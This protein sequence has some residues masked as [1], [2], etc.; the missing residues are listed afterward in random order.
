MGLLVIVPFLVLDVDSQSS[1]LFTIPPPGFIN[2]YSDI[3]IISNTSNTTG[4]TFDSYGS[5]PN[6][7]IAVGHKNSPSS[8][9]SAVIYFDHPIPILDNP[10]FENFNDEMTSCVARVISLNDIATVYVQGFVPPDNIEPKAKSSLVGLGLDFY[11]SSGFQ[12]PC[13]PNLETPFTN[14]LITSKELLIAIREKSDKS[15]YYFSPRD[16]IL[17]AQPIPSCTTS[18]YN[19][20][21]RTLKGENTTMC[22][23]INGTDMIIIT[24]RLAGFYGAADTVT[25]PDNPL[26]LN[27]GEIMTDPSADISRDNVKGLDGT[28]LGFDITT[29]AA[30]TATID[31]YGK[32]TFALSG[33]AN[34]YIYIP[35]GTT[36]SNDLFVAGD[37]GKACIRGHVIPSHF[38]SS[39]YGIPIDVSNGTA[40]GFAYVD[41]NTGNTKNC[42]LRG[43]NVTAPLDIDNTL[44]VVLY[45]QSDKEGYSYLRAANIT[46]SQDV[47]ACNATNFDNATKT[48]L[49]NT[50]M[51]YTD[52]GTD[53]VIYTKVMQFYGATSIDLPTSAT[54]D[55][56]D[57]LT[58]SGTIPDPV[59]T[60]TTVISDA[61]VKTG[62]ITTSSSNGHTFT[63]TNILADRIGSIFV[64]HEPRIPSND[65]FTTARSEC[66]LFPVDIKTALDN[67]YVTG[68]AIPDNIKPKA[69]TNLVALGFDMRNASGASVS[70]SPDLE[71]NNNPGPLLLDK[72]LYITLSNKSKKAPYYISPRDNIT[73]A[74]QITACSSDNFN[75]NNQTLKGTTEMCYGKNG[76]DMVI[77]T[78]RL[79]GF[80]GAANNVTAVS[81][82]DPSIP[83]PTDPPLPPGTIKIPPPDDF[84]SDVDD[85]GLGL[86]ATTT[87]V[88][89]TYTA[90][91]TPF[92]DNRHV[93]VDGPQ[94]GEILVP[95]TNTIMANPI[96]LLSQDVI[97]FSCNDIL[98]K[99]LNDTLDSISNIQPTS[100]IG[101]GY[102]FDDLRDS[103]CLDLFNATSDYPLIVEKE[104]RFTIYGKYDK[105][106]Y[107]ISLPEKIN[108]AQPIPACSSTN[109][110][111]NN[112]TLK[113][114]T[115]MC[116]GVNGTNMVIITKRISGYYGAADTVTPPTNPADLTATAPDLDVTTSRQDI[117]GIGSVAAFNITSGSLGL[118]M[119][120]IDSSGKYTYSPAASTQKGH[121]YIP[122][123]TYLISN[124]DLFVISDNLKKCISGYM[125][126]TEHTGAG[127][128]LPD[129]VTE[130]VAYGFAYNNGPE[131]CTLAATAMNVP[132]DTSTTFHVVLY[133]QAGKQG[134]SYLRAAGTNSSQDIAACSSTNFDNDTKILIHPT[135][136]CYTDVGDDLVIYSR[137]MQWYG[138]K[139]PST[140]DP[141][142]GTTD[143]TSRDN[144]KG[145]GTNP[146][147]DGLFNITTS[148]AGNGSIDASGK[149][150][151]IAGGAK[152][153][154]HIYIAPDTV[155]SDDLF[156][157][158]DVGK[159]CVQG[160][161]IPSDYSPSFSRPSDVSDGTAYGFA[162]IAGPD[163]DTCTL[164]LSHLVGQLNTS[165]TFQVVL[166]DQA[167]KVGYY[168]L[169]SIGINT[170]Q[171][172]IACSSTNFDDTSKTLKGTTRYCYKDVG[173]DLVIY[174]KVIQMYGAKT[175]GDTGADINTVSRD[176]VYGIGADINFNITTSAA[177]NGSIDTSGKYTWSAVGTQPKGHIYIPPDTIIYD[178]LFAAADVGKTCMQ[179]RVIPSDY[180]SIISRPSDLSDGTAYGFLYLVGADSDTCTLK[181]TAFIGQFNTSNTLQVVL[182]EQAGKEG[183]YYHPGININTSQDMTECS[184]TIF[185]NSTK[186]FKGTTKHCYADVGDDLVIYTKVLLWY[187]A[188]TPST[189]DLLTIPKP[190]N[191]P[192][193]QP[194]STHLVQYVDDPG[195]ETA[196]RHYVVD[197]TK[198]DI[199]NDIGVVIQDKPNGAVGNVHV[200]GYTSIDNYTLTSSMA[201][202]ECSIDLWSLS[203]LI[204]KDLVPSFNIPDNISP[205]DQITGLG[206][207]FNATHISDPCKTDIESST[208]HI[209]TRKDLRFTIYNSTGKQPYYFSPRENI[210]QAQPIPACTTDTIYTSNYTLKNTTEMCYGKDG[211]DLVILTKRLAFYGVNDTGSPSGTTPTPGAKTPLPLLTIPKPDD[212]PEPEKRGLTAAYNASKRDYWYV[213]TNITYFIETPS[214]SIGDVRVPSPDRLVLEQNTLLDNYKKPSICPGSFQSVGNILKG[215]FTQRAGGINTVV[216]LKIPSN[217]EEQ[218]SDTIIAGGI[219]WSPS[220]ESDKIKCPLDLEEQSNYPIF[221][222]KELRYTLYNQSDK[223]A[224]HFSPRENILA[225][226]PIPACSNDNFDITDQTLKGDT[227]M[228]YGKHENN[229]VI[230]TKTL[231][232]FYGA[233]TSIT[234]TSPSDDDSD[235]ANAPTFGTSPLT[236][237]QLVTCGYK[238]DDTC[239][240]ITAYHVQ[241]ERDTIQ[242]NTT[243]TFALKALAPN[244]VDS[245]TLAFGVPEVG[246]PVSV[247]E[248]YITAKLSVNYTS[249]SYYNIVQVT[250]HDPNNII[251]YDIANTEIA[252]VSCSGGTLECAQVTFSDVLFR[253]TL[254]HEPFVVMITDTLLYTSIN[255][256]NEGILVTGAPLNEQPTISPGITVDTGDIRP[257]KLVLV[258]T[259]KVNDLWADAF[260]NTW[261]RNSFGNYIIVEYAPYAGTVPVCSD[262]NDRL[263]APFKAKLDWHNQRM[264]ELRDSLYTAYTTKAYAEIDN[265]FAYEFGD[266]DSRTRTLINL[267][268]LTE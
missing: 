85:L 141:T 24:K 179:G 100:P 145:I 254:Y 47:P 247:A 196:F 127:F 36:I 219:N 157:A 210:V 30:G 164:K 14:P 10:I 116:Y 264:I 261:S 250:V 198:Y 104:L 204:N 32:Y 252:R 87:T 147:S 209:T 80:Y 120:G 89:N 78:K 142:P 249:P 153:K 57:L 243:H 50:K 52:V 193:L 117:S 152:Q 103:T 189:P 71:S 122:D 20:S 235:M 55:P 131:T 68:L 200:S 221:T 149:Y 37:A 75:T 268:W 34:G 233:T 220:I 229:M 25:T 21:A 260:G 239:R 33:I 173:G 126:S 119:G 41:D 162:G 192:Q 96:F 223:K 185:D 255:Y 133:D 256:M 184:S 151:Y 40:Y 125:A 156:A 124:I 4:Y 88:G 113:G 161:V 225:A 165:K 39:L 42:I 111:T 98:V 72:A 159:T 267:G 99:N 2:L 70:C 86:D 171:D 74:Q 203:D 101:L 16:N 238:M 212:M 138:A 29:T 56:S 43:A 231:T 245:F 105:K 121:I 84:P 241:Y 115:K 48:L 228:C 35:P 251:D 194:V 224:Y 168:Y 186:T 187:G 143:P 182:Y 158:A 146:L 123:S 18:I 132:F 77:L 174:A 211:N 51:C 234:V 95:S 190:S 110:D 128:T 66:D 19:Q 11:N 155:I 160:H 181:N 15:P 236:G 191:F 97:E 139:T 262:I 26:D 206:F 154:G 45:D 108:T 107:Y 135:K 31:T 91:L 64:P 82:P 79:A 248:A 205:S 8:K 61:G 244:M 257:T 44:Q 62:Y 69:K 114:D 49:N 208:E 58:I 3:S 93:S 81:S 94:I 170:A 226:Q 46:T 53:L 112:Q 265:I 38:S 54:T 73:S 27:S 92:G 169:R 202:S 163:S 134:Y 237:E 166:Y 230:I 227:K 17:E 140:P 63:H 258:R 102:V 22:Y 253:E 178:D 207:D 65:I 106:P 242:T 232:G 215:D 266:M 175:A 195:Q 7:P 144:I 1:S 172:I 263:C 137:V 150:S 67:N 213:R 76:T 109:F 13:S 180:S 197:D 136:Q 222:T 148:A 217:I 60:S 240:D 259:D 118:D 216:N 90:E 176:D 246:S 183:Y 23:G 199:D 5:S 167:G 177:G 28:L 214:S 218:T 9:V 83:D 129:D 12:F 201:I 6:V 188:K 59:F 130:G